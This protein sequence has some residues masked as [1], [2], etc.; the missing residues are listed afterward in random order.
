MSHDEHKRR[1][2]VI[3]DQTV[4]ILRRDPAALGVALDGSYVRGE[5]NAFSDIDLAC[6]LK[7]AELTGRE[8][9]Y[10]AVAGVAP[11]LCD[12]WLWNVHALYL[13]E[14][15][16]RL[17]LDFLPP[18]KLTGNTSISRSKILHDPTGALARAVI[19]SPAGKEE[20]AQ[21]SEPVD[22]FFWMFRQIVCWAKRGGQGGPRAYDK[23]SGAIDSLS[24]VRGT[25]QRMRLWTLGSRDYIRRADPLMA[26]RLAASFPKFTSEDILR[27]TRALLD[28]YER[29]GPDYCR[30]AGLEYPA[31][32]VA[33]MKRLVDEF[34]ALP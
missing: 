5:E 10:R 2:R 9:L 16:V 25:L 12:L 3:L 27:C 7:D 17:D 33:I 6:Y 11:L 4:D 31:Q 20:A 1:Q 13:F 22:W 32:K 21:P 15:G 18:A 26:D 8:P 34:D 28:E 23:L 14:N 24:Q 29:I 19:A 30:K